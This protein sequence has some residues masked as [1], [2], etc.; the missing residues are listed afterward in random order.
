MKKRKKKI[1][2]SLGRVIQVDDVFVYY[3]DEDREFH[4]GLIMFSDDSGDLEWSR[5]LSY[6]Y[7]DKEG[8]EI[9]RPF[10][11]Y[12][13]LVVMRGDLRD[14]DFDIPYTKVVILKR[15]DRSGKLGKLTLWS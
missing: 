11:N 2:D 8:S 15:L 10:E 14:F 4:Y 6:E 9:F 13:N 7:S 12:P 3:D 1:K 5:I